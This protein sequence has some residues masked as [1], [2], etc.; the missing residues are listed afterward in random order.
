[1]R[2]EIRT[3]QQLPEAL[4]MQPLVITIP[5]AEE[6]GSLSILPTSLSPL[7]SDTIGVGS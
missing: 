2:Q 4:S 1:M 5:G 6:R 7:R 3:A